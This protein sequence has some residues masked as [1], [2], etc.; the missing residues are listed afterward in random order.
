MMMMIMMMFITD[1]RSRVRGREF[2]ANSRG[3]RPRVGTERWEE[4]CCSGLA[5]DARERA[6]K[7]SK[8]SHTDLACGN[9]CI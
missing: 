7:G 8:S 2:D 4:A 3:K 6:Q 1:I 9:S 5:G